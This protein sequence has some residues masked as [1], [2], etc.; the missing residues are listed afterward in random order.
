MGEPSA[1]PKL[2]HI[3]HG[4]NLQNVIEAGRLWSDERMRDHD[5]P[6]ISIGISEIKNERLDRDMPCHPGTK[7]G[8]FVP[9]YLCPRSVMLYLISKGNHPNLDYQDGQ[10]PILHLVADLQ[11]VVAWAD[12]EGR[13]WAFTDRNARS[14]YFRAFRDLRELNGL[15]WEAIEA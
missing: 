11:D 3:T 7:V 2:Y 9:F 15:N 8:H 4:K 10:R 5:G 14:S 6:E 1:R 12:Q 13:R